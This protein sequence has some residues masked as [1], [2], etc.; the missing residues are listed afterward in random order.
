[1]VD[2]RGFAET[3]VTLVIARAPVPR[4]AFYELFDGL[5]DCLIAIMDVTMERACVLLDEAFAREGSWY[6][7]LRWALAAVLEFLD[8][9]PGLARVSIVHVLA[10]GP[11]VLEHRERT[12]DMFYRR[13]AA[14]IGVDPHSALPLAFESVMA[15]VLGVIHRRLVTNDPQPLL[16]L[17]GPLMG[18]IVGPYLNAGAVVGE[19]EK[20]NQLA[21]RMLGERES[22][23]S[24][25]PEIIAIPDVL[26]ASG[27]HRA[28][29]CLLYVAAEPGAS[30]RE[31]A[32]GIDVTHQGQI[33][34]LLR[35]LGGLG[36][37]A[38]HSRGPGHPNA[39]S[40]TDYGALVAQAISQW[41]WRDSAI[42]RESG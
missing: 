32:R 15:T 11:A 24:H 37:L 33:S 17:L 2:E 27:A 22:E 6:Q 12:I 25:R 3:S 4:R 10:A 14:G 39:W 34:A 19:I 1:V 16:A 13:V 26:L 18:S 41:D 21:R 36:L 40:V 28:R 8:A 9:E 20:G 35:R 7:R 42:D 5:D 38:K 31:V 30:N 29:S 23:A